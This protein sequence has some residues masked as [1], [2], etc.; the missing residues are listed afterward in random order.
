VKRT[1]RQPA[2]AHVANRR[3]LGVRRRSGSSEIERGRCATCHNGWITNCLGCHV[4]INV[5][6]LQRDKVAPDG[7]IT[8]SAGENEIWMSN[9]HNPGH[10]NFQLLGLLRAPFVLGVASNSEQGRLVTVRSSMEVFASATDTTGDTLRENL[11]FTTFQTVD[12][13]SGRNNVATSG[14]VMNQTMAH[15]VRPQEARGCEMCH[16]LVDNGGRVRNEHLLA[17][18]LRP[19]TPL[20]FTGT[21]SWRPARTGSS[22]S[23]TSKSASSQ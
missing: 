10:I 17:Q 23:S 5:G 22:C 21:G 1:R 12:G 11:T 19:G 15:T 6:D 4:D 7:S 13:N 8:K 14:V 20:P 2:D 9:T 18:T 16:P 3:G